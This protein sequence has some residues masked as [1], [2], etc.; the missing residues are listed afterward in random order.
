M[1]KR[2]F[3][4]VIVA[5]ME[6]LKPSIMANQCS[7]SLR[8]LSRN[9]SLTS[10]R[11]WALLSIWTQKLLLPQGRLL[12]SWDR[13]QPIVHHG[14]I[15]LSE[16]LICLPFW[17]LHLYRNYLCFSTNF[18]NFSVSSYVHLVALFLNSWLRC[19]S[20][21]QFKISTMSWSCSLSSLGFFQI[22]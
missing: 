6:S 14:T 3:S 4:L 1:K 19:F 13:L 22:L 2:R 5:P 7:A 21:G 16:L 11:F 12:S 18:I 17:K 8:C 20:R 15:Y 10:W 9:L